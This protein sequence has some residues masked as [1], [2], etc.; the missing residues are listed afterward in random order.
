SS[1]ASRDQVLRSARSVQAHGA[2]STLGDAG[3]GDLYQQ[4]RLVV[5]DQVSDGETGVPARAADRI[6]RADRAHLRGNDLQAIVLL[7]QALR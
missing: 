1:A 5:Q 7:L 4:L 2:R 3:L 6:A